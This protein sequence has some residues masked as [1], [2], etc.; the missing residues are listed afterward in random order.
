MPETNSTSPN[1]SGNNRG[2]NL[3]QQ[4]R[5]RGGQTS[6]AKQGRDNQGQFAGRSAG[7]A[8]NTGNDRDMDAQ[9][10]QGSGGDNNP[11]SADNDSGGRGTNR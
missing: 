4:D 8:A 9:R 3:S 2:S 7:D 1:S 6:A 5:I 11:R 10:G